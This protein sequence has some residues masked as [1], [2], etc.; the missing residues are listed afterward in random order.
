MTIMKHLLVV[1]TFLPILAMFMTPVPVHADLVTCGRGPDI[2][3]ACTLC[4]IVKGISVLTT[5]IRD[6][7]VFIALAV[8][9]AMGI[10]Y[11]VSAGNQEM[12]ETAKKGIWAS[13][14]GIAIILLAWVV[15]NTIM[16]VVF[17]A[18]SGNVAVLKNFSLATGFVFDCEAA[19]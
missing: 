4:D 17:D 13:L 3:S 11:I 10:M 2:N 14:A 7:M 9:T 19:L 1:V 18:G 16:F 6:I 12:M 15:V 8:I 5:Y